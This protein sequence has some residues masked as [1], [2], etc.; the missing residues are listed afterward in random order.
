MAGLA[1]YCGAVAVALGVIAVAVFLSRTPHVIPQIPQIP[2]PGASLPPPGTKF[3]LV[4]AGKMSGADIL[5]VQIAGFGSLLAGIGAIACGT[6]AVV[7]LL[8]RKREQ[9]E[10]R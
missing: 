7:L 1:A 2:S 5:L 9:P 3:P 6:V 4:Y 10:Y 8:R